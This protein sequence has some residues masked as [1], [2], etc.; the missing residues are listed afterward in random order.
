MTDKNI[1]NYLMYTEA[2]EVK[3]HIRY[4]LDRLTKDET[5]HLI[6]KT[7]HGFSVI[8]F[9]KQAESSIEKLMVEIDKQQEERVNE[10]QRSKT[11]L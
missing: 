8:A 10:L 5:H 3:K 11:L 1:Q 4:Y 7:A 9:L 2:E 6:Q